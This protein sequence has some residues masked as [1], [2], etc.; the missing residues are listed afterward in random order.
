MLSG[1]QWLS[2]PPCTRL[3]VKVSEPA[4]GLLELTGPALPTRLMGGAV[5][6][7][8]AT[9]A[10]RT[11]PLL[12][13]PIPFP[14]KLVPLTLAAVGGGLSVAGAM[15]ATATC[16]VRVERK[17]GLTFRWHVR[18]FAP[19]EHHVP[20]EEVAA[21]EVTRHVFSHPSREDFGSDRTS[22]TYRLVLVTKAGEALPMEEFGTKAQ[23][24]L[25]KETLE[26]VLGPAPRKRGSGRRPA[27]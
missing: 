26:Q 4:Q 7:F 13:L 21:F 9:F 19:R 14:F 5:A 12:R 6:A 3:K 11:A 27:A 17:E 22:V 10:A 23:A 15:T 24:T 2:S 16:S 25:R 20:P 8:G 1:M 18:P